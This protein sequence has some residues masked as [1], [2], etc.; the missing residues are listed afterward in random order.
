MKG[1]LFEEGFRPSEKKTAKGSG[2]EN[3]KRKTKG[4]RASW[5][6]ENYC[7]KQKAIRKSSSESD[8]SLAT[9]TTG[10]NYAQTY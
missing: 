5:S 2:D 6:K 1:C 3:E 7:E 9:S 10:S 4:E 8:R